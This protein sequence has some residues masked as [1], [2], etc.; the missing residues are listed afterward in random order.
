MKKGYADLLSIISDG[1]IHSG[2]ELADELSISRAAI[3]KSIKHLRSLGLIIEATHGKGYKL[4]QPMEL[5]SA[6][7]ISNKLS[8]IASRDCNKIDILFNTPSTNSCLFERLEQSSIHGHVVLA[9]Y[10]SAGKGRRGNQWL[11]AL[12]AGIYLS[13]GWHFDR[14]PAA[15]GL[16]S[17]YTAVAI[18]RALKSLGIDEARLKWPN[19][20]L[21]DNEKL[22]GV[23][24]EIRGESCGAM[25]VVIGIGVNYDLPE[26][27][28]ENIEQ[29]VTDIC[30]HS[31]QQ[32]SRN[33]IVAALISHV[34]DVFHSITEETYV[35]LLNEWRQYDYYKNKTAKLML[36]DKE[37]T[38]LL[39]G[40]DEQGSLLMLVDGKTE[41]Y[42]SGEISL[43]MLE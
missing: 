17:L 19:D 31:P 22:G 10:Q 29:A 25:D 43:R 26:Y 1:E 38:G 8:S 33:N 34:I 41:R 40:V 16:L 23:L 30:K 36:P 24:L 11:S 32:L 7:K 21:I 35:E 15:P 39:Q 2:E 42:T 3:W 5:L 28:I 18:V 37:I 20:I 6:E 4:H 13:L 27:I 9:E 12:G 14:S